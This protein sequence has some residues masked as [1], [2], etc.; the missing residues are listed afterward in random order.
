M[1]PLPGT[2]QAVVFD[3]DGLLIDS[4]PLWGR[5]EAALVEAHG[6]RLT[7]ADRLATIGRSIDASIAIHAERLGLPASTLPDLRRELIAT[8]RVLYATEGVIRPG[9]AELVDRLTGRLPLGLA[10]NS[11]RDLV[12]LALARIGLAGRFQTIVTAADVAHAKPAPDAYLELCARLGADPLR[13]IGFEDSP[14][15][16]EA[17][18]AAGIAAV[19]V[20]AG[21]PLD[22]RAADV[23]VDSLVEVLDWVDAA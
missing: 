8:V 7:R 21:G 15:G 16:V 22:L 4:E 11:D 1:F 5:A 17:L 20:L 10:S 6:G 18:R 19:G 14:S 13:A 12:D 3:M 9:A 23:V 2:F